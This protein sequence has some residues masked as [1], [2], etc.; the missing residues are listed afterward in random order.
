MTTNGTPC[1]CNECKGVLRSVKIVRRHAKNTVADA[2]ELE[3]IQKSPGT[4][5]IGQSCAFYRTLYEQHATATQPLYAGSKLSVL[6]HIYIEMR[7]FV[8]HP[9]YTKAAVTANF[10]DD[11]L[12]KLPQPNNSCKTFEDARTKIKDFLVP[13]QTFH[14]CPSDC[15]IYRGALSDAIVSSVFL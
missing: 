8:A 3:L 15:V 2:N 10:K 13:L 9:F 7:K 4:V 6:E 14:A 1:W 11:R 5:N 12:L